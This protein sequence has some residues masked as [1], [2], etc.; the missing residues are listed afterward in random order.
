MEE[1][2]AEPKELTLTG[3]EFVIT[4]RLETFSRQEAEALI[5]ELGGAVSSSVTKKTTDLVV[6]A[7]PGSKLDKARNLGIRILTEEEFLQLIKEGE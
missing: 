3:R 5:K 4:G 1:A 6:G 2:E 7:E